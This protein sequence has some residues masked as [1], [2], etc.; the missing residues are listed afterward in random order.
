MVSMENRA[1]LILGIALLVSLGGA[2]GCTY[3]RHHIRPLPTHGVE[4]LDPVPKEKEKVIIADYMIEPPDVLEITGIRL[5]P[6]VP[7]HL[8]VG[9][10]VIVEVIGTLPDAPIRGEFPV[11]IGGQINL[12]F[13][14]GSVTIMGMTVEEAQEAIHKHLLDYLRQPD[15][16]VSLGNI[17]SAQQITGPHLVAQD[18]KVNLGTYGTVSVVGL[19]I[20]Q[21]KEAIE[22]HLSEELEEPDVALAVANYNS[23]FYYIITQGAGLGD[24]FQ[25]LPISGN[26][27]VLDAITGL[28][29]LPRTSSTK[30]WVARPGKGREGLDQILKVDYRAITQLGETATNYQ[31]LPGDRLFISENKWTRL[32]TDI[33]TI[34]RPFQSAAQ[35]ATF[36]TNVATRFSGNVLRGGAN[37]ATNIN[38]DGGLIGG[39]IGIPGIP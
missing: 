10:T 35:I 33:N 20:E 36:F 29:Q 5:S 21:A 8:Q 39:G 13:G 30:M 38:T 37:P 14:Y 1:R 6:K 4:G 34:A 26:E 7:Y 32:D 3:T 11:Q 9:D 16:T 27:T 22:E 28:G 25:R 24:R 31:L 19:T 18:G 15:V 12:R 17:A 2:S 23:K